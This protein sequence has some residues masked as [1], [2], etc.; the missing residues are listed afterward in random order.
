MAANAG[1]ATHAESHLKLAVLVGV[2]VH[3][4][5]RE[6]AGPIPEVKESAVNGPQLVSV[7]AHDRLLLVFVCWPHQGGRDVVSHLSAHWACPNSLH[8][9][10]HASVYGMTCSQWT[11][12]FATMQVTMTALRLIE[13]C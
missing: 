7:C 8:A 13:M 11:P 3:A 5:S 12:A 2:A 9:C 1:H 10:Q 4:G 6:R